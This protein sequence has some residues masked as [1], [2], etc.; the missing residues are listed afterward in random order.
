MQIETDRVWPPLYLGQRQ[1]ASLHLLRQC[2][3]T[4]WRPRLHSR[5][6]VLIRFRL[7][8]ADIPRR[9]HQRSSGCGVRQKRSILSSSWSCKMSADEV[10]CWERSLCEDRSLEVSC[11]RS[12]SLAKT[13]D[14]EDESL[15]LD[16]TTQFST[17]YLTASGQLHWVGRGN[18]RHRICRL[19]LSLVTRILVV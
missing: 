1:H 9:E 13:C 3:G 2:L 6:I 14:S 7:V 5:R 15:R 8:Q 19:R 12:T 17:R 18:A 16:I 10:G 4:A 11:G